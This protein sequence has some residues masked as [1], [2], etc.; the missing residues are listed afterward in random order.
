MG[1]IKIEV[2]TKYQK[3]KRN[4]WIEEISRLSG[5]FG[6]DAE[7]IE[8]EITEEIKQDGIHSLLGHLRLCGTIPERYGHDT[9]EEKLYS[10]Y[11]DVVIHSG[12]TA[13]GFNSIVVKE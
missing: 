5:N 3:D 10:K 12:F 13:I 7:K 2:I 8:H 11:T 1:D 6:V 4:Y 9:S